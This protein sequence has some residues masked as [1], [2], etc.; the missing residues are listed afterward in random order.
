M[1]LEELIL[2]LHRPT[3]RVL[4]ILL[5]LSQNEDGLS[6]TEISQ[7]TDIPKSTISPILRTLEEMKFVTLNAHNKYAIGINALKVGGTFIKSNSGIDIIRSF[8]EEI[9]DECNEVCQL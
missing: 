5:L 2:N 7:L 8:M 4:D 1:K 6:H 9:V 3:Q